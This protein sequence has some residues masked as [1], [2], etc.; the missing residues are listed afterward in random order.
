MKK[1]LNK[2]ALAFSILL[3]SITSSLAQNSPAKPDVEALVKAYI[4]A[5]QETD[6]LKR[7][8][9]LTQI[10][11]P[12]GIYLD[13]QSEVK[14][15][16]KLVEYMGL[17]MQMNPSNRRVELSNIES[18]HGTFRFA[19]RSVMPDGTVLNEGMDFGEVDNNGRIRRLVIFIGPLLPKA[20][21]K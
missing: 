10:W 16:Q 21:S 1:L 11:A 13:S 15:R 8:K 18:H 19:W 6:Y 4:A 17:V 12:N 3:I 7:E 9:L 5:W 14:G 2:L 20:E